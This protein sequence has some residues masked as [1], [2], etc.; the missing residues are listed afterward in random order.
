[1]I[2]ELQMPEIDAVL[3]KEMESETSDV[4]RKLA[5][6][7]PEEMQKAMM[8]SVPSGAGYKGGRRS[9]KGQPPA[10]ATGNLLTSVH[11][12]VLSNDTAEIEMAYYAEFLDP[13]F[14]KG[15]LDRPF[16]EDSITKSL[17]R[18]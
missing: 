1:M 11:G 15:Y 14:D 8:L 6:Y 10:I 7:A 4:I 17:E 13:F 2:F 9:A 16:I 5:D 12:A 3:E 18:L